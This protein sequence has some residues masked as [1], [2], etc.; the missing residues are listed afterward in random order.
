MATS[1][2]TV[3]RATI[4]DLRAIAGLIEVCLDEVPVETHLKNA[5]GVTRLTYIADIQG[6][7]CG[8]V[9]GFFTR[10]VEGALRF[11]VDLLAVHPCVRGQGIAATLINEACRQ[12]AVHC[13]Q[14]NRALVRVDNAASERAFRKSGFSGQSDVYELYVSNTHSLA[15]SAEHFV[16]VVTLTYSGHWLEGGLQP[17]SH[18]DVRPASSALLGAVVPKG[19]RA[20]ALLDDLGFTMLG[21]FH[22]WIHRAKT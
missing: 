12:A 14:L 20:S 10:S 6:V 18:V 19:S 7:I 21:K 3:R 22:W 17:V 16:P 15:V 1:T 4:D 11:E 13:P 9:D 2:L 5:F 8:F